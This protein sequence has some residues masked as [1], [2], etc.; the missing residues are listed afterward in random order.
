[1]ARPIPVRAILIALIVVF[2]FPGAAL[3][4]R[5]IAAF[6]DHFTDS[7]SEGICGIQVDTELLITDNFF[8]YADGS[9]KDTGSFVATYTNPENGNSVVVSAAGPATGTVLIDEQAGTITFVTSYFGL[10]EKIQTVDGPVLTLDAGVITFADTFDLE[11]EE[12][13]G[14]EVTSYGPHPEADNDFALFCEVVT[15]ALT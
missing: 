4:A 5:P 7:F 14:A 2:A 6:H 10:P 9:F 12:F 8:A 15:E 1:M 13:L 3:A 11:T